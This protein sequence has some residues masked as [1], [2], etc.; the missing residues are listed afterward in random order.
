MS[1]RRGKTHD[2]ESTKGDIPDTCISD[3]IP[4]ISDDDSPGTMRKE[5]PG[6]LAP[7][8]TESKSWTQKFMLKLTQEIKANPFWND[9]K[10]WILIG[11]F[12]AFQLMTVAYFINSME[13]KITNLKSCQKR[14]ANSDKSLSCSDCM[15]IAT[16][17]FSSKE[18]EDVIEN[19]KKDRKKYQ[20]LEKANVDLLS[21]LSK[22]QEQVAEFKETISE[23]KTKCSD[24]H[25][26][27]L[28]G[29][30]WKKEKDIFTKEI[31]KA[32]TSYKVSL[33]EV[34]SNVEKNSQNVFSQIEKQRKEITEFK[35]KIQPV[36]DLK[37]QFEEKMDKV[38]DELNNLLDKYQS[39]EKKQK[40]EEERI[41]STE[42]KLGGVERQQNYVFKE[43]NDIHL[44]IILFLV[45]V[46]I[47]VIF[48]SQKLLLY[49]QPSH[50]AERTVYPVEAMSMRSGPNQRVGGQEVSRAELLAKVS[51][52]KLEKGIGIISFHSSTQEFHQNLLRVVPKPHSLPMQTYLIEKQEDLLKVKPYKVTIV[53]VDFNERNIILE[54]PDTEVGD[55]R[56]LT[57]EIFLSSK[58]DVFVVYCK[59][60]DSQSLP[61]NQ[62]YNTK[63]HS[64]KQ[65]P[66]LSKLS[67]ENRVFSVN[68]AL[69]PQQAQLLENCFKLL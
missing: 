38:N 46:V 56:R 39:L 23:F 64:V 68:K 37:A 11:T 58:C 69:L 42:K 21:Q 62:L 41:N 13:N 8:S 61:P 49:R 18:F 63:L 59:D 27:K 40:F 16:D 54:N 4:E 55:C 52:K 48:A 6:Y 60:R 7:L 65:Q 3:E 31:E 22:Y 44:Y 53:F 50:T 25:V 29:I 24:D 33:D 9:L 66:I 45:V 15:C 26:T 12:L 57:T 51:S 20:E 14:I 36:D 5:D 34:Q 28:F 43:I 2:R 1:K 32:E 19:Q 30:N 35:E 47:A 17:G 10:F 67:K